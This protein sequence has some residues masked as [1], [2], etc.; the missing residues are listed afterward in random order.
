MQVTLVARGAGRL[1]GT[2]GVAVQVAPQLSE[3]W[4]KKFL[5]DTPMFRSHS[6]GCPCGFTTRNECNG[7]YCGYNDYKAC[8]GF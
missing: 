6:G 7:E 4:L 5:Y 8:E 1:I 3:T 2:H